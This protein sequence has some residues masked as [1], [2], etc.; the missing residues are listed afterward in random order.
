MFSAQ[1]VL[2]TLGVSLCS[3]IYLVL[4][5]LFSLYVNRT[6]VNTFHFLDYFWG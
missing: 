4:F 3:L 6:N 1:V 5:S 2:S